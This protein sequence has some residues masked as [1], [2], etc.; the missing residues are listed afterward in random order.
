MAKPRLRHVA[1][2]AGVSQATVSRVLNEKE[3]VAEDTRR[4]V[5]NALDQLGYEPVGTARLAPSRGGL[6]GLIVPE[7]TNPIFPA[8]AESIEMQLAA[9]GFTTVVCTSTPAGRH[10]EEYVEVLLQRGTDGFVFLS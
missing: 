10:E 6:V 4:R 8:F 1:E 7:L 5:L 9:A 3:G 2:I